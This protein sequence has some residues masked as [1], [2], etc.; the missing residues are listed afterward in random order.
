MISG[1][2]HG[3]RVAYHAS[4]T[5]RMQDKRADWHLRADANLRFSN[6]GFGLRA[7]HASALLISAPAVAD[8]GLRGR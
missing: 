1:A 4:A 6:R 2:Y 8:P 7:Y 3:I 5:P